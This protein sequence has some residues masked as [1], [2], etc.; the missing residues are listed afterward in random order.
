MA[1]ASSLDG[2]EQ[3][4]QERAIPGRR[5]SPQEFQSPLHQNARALAAFPPVKPLPSNRT[6]VKKFQQ[7]FGRTSVG[8]NV[9]P[10]SA[11]KTRRRE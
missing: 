11:K 5:P 1:A 4:D 6:T 10:G 2:R 3:P 9:V 7:R 8:T